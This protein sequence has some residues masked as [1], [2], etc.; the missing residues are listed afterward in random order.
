MCFHYQGLCG[1][2]PKLLMS[3]IFNANLV[4]VQQ[5]TEKVVFYCNVSVACVQPVQLQVYFLS[6]TFLC[7]LYSTAILTTECQR[8]R[9]VMTNIKKLTW[10]YHTLLFSLAFHILD[11]MN[12]LMI[13]AIFMISGLR[14]C[15]LMGN[16]IVTAVG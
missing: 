15:L 1:S 3:T 13:L 14:A 5:S 6:N 16:F 10:Q 2:I 4:T 9:F 11:T 12:C 7:I 8:L